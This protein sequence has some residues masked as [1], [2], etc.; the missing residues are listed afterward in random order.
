M[1]SSRIYR[2]MNWLE[3]HR[4]LLYEV[5]QDARLLFVCAQDR[6]PNV[7]L[8]RLDSVVPDEKG[9]LW[10]YR[11]T[12]PDDHVVQPASSLLGSRSS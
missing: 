3:E 4:T 12:I 10:R 11:I 2:E 7:T 5:E 6:W 8:T 1:P 9:R